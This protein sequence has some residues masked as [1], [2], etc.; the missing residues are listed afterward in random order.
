MTPQ[1][2]LHRH[3]IAD[4]QIIRDLPEDA[5][6]TAVAEL[7][8]FAPAPKRPGEIQEVLTASLDGK[9][10]GSESLLRQLLSLHGLARQLNL[11]AEEVFSGIS[12]GLNKSECGWT[13]EELARWNSVVTPLRDL[14]ELQVVRLTSKALDLAYEHPELL[15]RARILTD[16]RPV[17]SDDAKEIRGSVVSHSLL[18]RYDDTE[19]NHTMSLAVDEDDLRSLV[20]QC[21]R[22]LTKSETAQA[23]LEKKAGTPAIVPGR[24]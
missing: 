10:L 22:A 4:L 21:E 13:H 2:R 9:R 16:I 6:R 18:I 5:L 3:Q 19:G 12:E 7:K 11:S 23:F 15:Q 24:Y 17:F 8:R 1:I 20:K 14:F